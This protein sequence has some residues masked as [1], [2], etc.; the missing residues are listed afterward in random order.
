MVGVVNAASTSISDCEF[1]GKGIYTSG[2]SVVNLYVSGASAQ[3]TVTNCTFHEPVVSG[4][5]VRFQIG[6]SGTVNL[7]GGTL[8]VQLGLLAGAGGFAGAGPQPGFC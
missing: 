8:T 4:E 2:N 7:D 5:G 3:A 6:A 1:N